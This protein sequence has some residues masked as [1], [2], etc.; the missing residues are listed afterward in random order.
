[1]HSPVATY[2]N[3][4]YILEPTSGERWYYVGWTN[5]PASRLTSHNA[6]KVRATIPRKPYRMLIIARF[7]TKNAALRFEQAVKRN[8]PVK[9]LIVRLAGSL[10]KPIVDRS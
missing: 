8:T 4:V 9:Y 1:M 3:C 2:A 5:T 10:R 6:G 7:R